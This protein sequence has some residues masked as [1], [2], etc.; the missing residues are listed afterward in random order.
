M[1]ELCDSPASDLD[2]ESIRPVLDKVMH[3]LKESDRD[4]I[5]MRYF[6]NRQLADIGEKLGLSEDAAR[7]RVDRA[8][9]KLR[10]FLSRSGVTAT[11][12]AAAL[13]DRWCGSAYQIWTRFSGGRYKASPGL[14][15]NALYQGSKFRT[16]PL[17]RYLAGECGSVSSSWRCRPSRNFACQAWA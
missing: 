7:K 12:L 14:M 5:L 1:H 13:S 15:S 2:W 11:A 10:G 17:T 3:K 4:V 8:L 6:E 9:E 16:M